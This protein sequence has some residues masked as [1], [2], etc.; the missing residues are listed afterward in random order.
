M[1][2][3]AT[4]ISN[5]STGFFERARILAGPR[6]NRW[7][8]PPATLAIHLCIGMAYGFSVF[9]LPLSRAIGLTAPK[10]CPDLTLLG[11]L[12]TTSC[13]WRISSLG[14]MFTLFFVV[15]GS[16]AALWGG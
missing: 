13:D 5:I 7:L 3:S 16:S 14:W 6:F 9:W 15:L 2:T 1:S 11:E 12:F 10:A 8:V 4:G